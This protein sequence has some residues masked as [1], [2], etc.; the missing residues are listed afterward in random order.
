MQ[1]LFE[2]TNQHRRADWRA[3]CEHRD[4]RTTNAPNCRL[5]D[6][7]AHIAIIRESTIIASSLTGLQPLASS[8][9]PA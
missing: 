2:H 4:A 8:H 6:P 3:H 9:L 7:N 5:N 1:L